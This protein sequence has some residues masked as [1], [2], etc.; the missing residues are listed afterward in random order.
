MAVHRRDAHKQI[1]TVLLLFARYHMFWPYTKYCDYCRQTCTSTATATAIHSLDVCFILICRNAISLVN[2]PCVA[3]TPNHYSTVGRCD[4]VRFCCADPF[5][6][7]E[8]FCATESRSIHG[9]SK[10]QHEYAKT[11]HSIRYRL[12]LKHTSTHTRTHLHARTN[13][14]THAHSNRLV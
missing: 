7:Y 10:S 13:A 1:F 5:F 2:F 11:L 14:R 4:G 9:S 8:F 12:S 3:Y 6:Y